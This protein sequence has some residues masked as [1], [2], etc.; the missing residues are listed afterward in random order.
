[1]RDLTRLRR[2]TDDAV[3][4]LRALAD[5]ARAKGL[6]VAPRIECMAADLGPM[7]RGEI[8]DMEIDA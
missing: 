7:V 4:M 5:E 6:Y 8:R 2:L 1:M 3:A